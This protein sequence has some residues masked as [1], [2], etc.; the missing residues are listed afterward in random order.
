MRDY[1]YCLLQ[2]YST[3]KRPSMSSLV[4]DHIGNTGVD[5]RLGIDLQ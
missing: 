4:V 2:T 3:N 5:Y 1:N